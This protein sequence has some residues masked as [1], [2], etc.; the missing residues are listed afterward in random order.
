MTRRESSGDD[1]VLE[2]DRAGLL[3]DA[4]LFQLEPRSPGEGYSLRSAR[5]GLIRVA[6]VAGT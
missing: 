5:V 6:R 2:S 4:A 1:V 3:I